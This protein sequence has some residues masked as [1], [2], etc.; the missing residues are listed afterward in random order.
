[1]CIETVNVPFPWIIWE[2][3]ID[4]QQELILVEML[5]LVLSMV[6]VSISVPWLPSAPKMC[7]DDMNA[8]ASEVVGANRDQTLF[9]IG[10]EVTTGRTFQ[11]FQMFNTTG[12]Q[13]FT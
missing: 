4:D 8:H 12:V 10:D 3:R 6:E 5:R 2:F 7:P 9:L 1:M 13:P 11:A